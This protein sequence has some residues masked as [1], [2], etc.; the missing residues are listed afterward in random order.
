MATVY[1]NSPAWVKRM[2][3]F[4]V[5]SDLNKDGYLSIEDFD[6]WSDNLEREV[7]ADASLL[8]KSRK[9]TRDFW[10]A[11]GLEPGVLL[12]KDQFIDN[13][14]KLSAAEKARLDDGKDPLF[15]TFIDAVFDAVD[16]SNDG[17]LQLDEYEKMMKV[18]NFDAGTAKIVFDII[19]ANHDGKLS[20]EEVRRY[21]INFWFT[22]D[23][24]KAAGLYG[25]KFEQ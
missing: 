2:E 9:A 18:S 20:R 22:P 6:L 23:H 19:D 3:E 10:V 14:S 1:K 5:Q 24:P 8:Q 11:S 4:F 25:P 12:T 21:N 17:Y 13:M 7:K 16:T 15:Y